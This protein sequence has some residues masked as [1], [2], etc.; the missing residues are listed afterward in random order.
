MNFFGE[1]IM[2]VKDCILFQIKTSMVRSDGLMVPQFIT[3][4]GLRVN[5]LILSSDGT[6]ELCIQVHHITNSYLKGY[7]YLMNYTHS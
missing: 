7:T 2:K 6:V 1:S 5:Q 4:T 3:P